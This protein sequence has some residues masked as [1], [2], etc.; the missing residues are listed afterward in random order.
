MALVAAA[1]LGSACDQG[2]RVLDGSTTPLHVVAAYPAPD[3]GVAC[4][5]DPSCEGVPLN[6][7]IEL[8]FDRYLDP[9]SAVR[10]S[11]RLQAGS[12]GPI[13]FLTPSY[14]VVERVVRFRQEPGARLQPST[15]YTV[16]LIAEA[17]AGFR[18]FDGAALEHGAIPE[19][20]HFYTGTQD[21]EDPPAPPVTSCSDVLRIF[22]GG[23]A[24]CVSCHQSSEAGIGGCPPGQAPDPSFP[25]ECVGVPRQGLDLSSRAGLERT[26]VFQVAHQTEI[27]PSAGTPLTN[28]SRV[29]VQMPLVHPNNP[30]NSYLLYKLLR[31]PSNFATQ[32]TSAYR[33]GLGGQRLLASDDERERLREW[34]VRGEPMPAGG[35]SLS[36]AEVRAI[37]RWIQNGAETESCR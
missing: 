11:L 23:Q 7:A 19:R 6:L 36:L 12:G 8:R 18:A 9:S 2:E 33:V 3:E 25:D 10:Q 27:G 22:S 24:G 16:E 1:Y 29:G 34:F 5:G 4:V 35:Y 32:Q 17:G 13:V 26:A 37:Q 15:L 20:Y 28:P 21:A 31:N 30:G 14:D